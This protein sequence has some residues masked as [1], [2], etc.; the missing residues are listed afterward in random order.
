M[1]GEVRG[2]AGFSV[3]ADP[4][5]YLVVDLANGGYSFLSDVPA[6]GWTDEY[7][8]SKM[9]F[10][11]IPAGTY[12]LGYPEEDFYR[13]EA[14]NNWNRQIVRG[15]SPRNVTL[16]SDFYFSIFLTTSSQITYIRGDSVKGSSTVPQRAHNGYSLF[17]GSLQDD[18]ETQVDWPN[19]GYTVAS[20][21]YVGLLREKVGG[22]L[23]IDL[24]TQEQWEIAMRAGTDTLW[25]SGGRSTNTVDELKAFLTDIAWSKNI[26]EVLPYNKSV[27]L[28]NPNNWGVYDF[29]V[30]YEATLS[31]ANDAADITYPDGKRFDLS[32]PVGGVD[33]VGP[34]SSIHSARVFMGGD[35]SGA[36]WALRNFPTPM[37]T[38]LN[39]SDGGKIY[40]GLR[41]AVHLKPLVEVD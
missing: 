8:T 2:G 34:N 36:S 9:V 24:P 4:R 15:M 17:R 7:K 27:G 6:G 39:V 3:A 28:K 30:M 33:P 14:E 31:Y 13:M 10:K 38:G 5:T 23:L 35:S 29:N 32:Y 26:E 1:G 41:F 16:T 18:G 22:G 20:S 21:S 19:S 25:P 40:A 11:R 37:R 12:S